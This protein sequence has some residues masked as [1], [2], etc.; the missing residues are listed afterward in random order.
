MNIPGYSSAP[1]H[2]DESIVDRILDSAVADPPDVN[3]PQ[4]A[5]VSPNLPYEVGTVPQLN[6]ADF[7]AALAPYVP[8]W[9]HPYARF[10][11]ANMGWLGEL[12][13]E[14]FRMF[15]TSVSLA[16]V[17][18]LARASRSL[19]AI[20]SSASSPYA[21]LLPLI[22]QAWTD[23]IDIAHVVRMLAA[24]EMM[25]LPLRPDAF[26]AAASTQGVEPKFASPAYAIASAWEEAIMRTRDRV[27]EEI[28]AQAQLQMLIDL[29]VAAWRVLNSYSR[30]T[31]EAL[32]RDSWKR[33]QSIPSA[34]WPPIFDAAAS[35]SRS[36]TWLD[37]KSIVADHTIRFS[38]ISDRVA[39]AFAAHPQ[40]LAEGMLT[41][42]VMGTRFGMT[43]DQY[44]RLVRPIVATR[45]YDLRNGTNWA[46]SDFWNRHPT[47]DPILRDMTERIGLEHAFSSFWSTGIQQKMS[48]AFT[49]KCESGDID[50]VNEVLRWRARCSAFFLTK[51]SAA[52]LSPESG[53]PSEALAQSLMDA[54]S[55]MSKKMKDGESVERCL[56]DIFKQ[57]LRFQPLLLDRWA[58]AIFWGG[59]N[60]AYVPLLGPI[61][62]W[63]ENAV[64]VFVSKNEY[65]NATRACVAALRSYMNIT[66]MNR[67]V[68]MPILTF[69]TQKVFDTMPSEAWGA[70][71][72]YL[73]NLSEQKGQNSWISADTLDTLNGTFLRNPRATLRDEANGFYE[74]L[75]EKAGRIFNQVPDLVAGNTSTF[76]HFCDRLGIP[77]RSRESA[78]RLILLSIV[79]RTPDGTP[80]LHSAV[81]AELKRAGFNDPGSFGYALLAR[82]R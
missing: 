58:E 52:C 37:M 67:R 48:V 15:L 27:Y 56:N 71:L 35:R 79:E 5:G 50:A 29:D 1:Y 72:T 30:E 53:L 26:R 4:N 12:P 49:M 80:H 41:L 43:E 73:D 76:D 51:E 46:F 18:T 13:P 77:I 22:E 82:R 54:I 25:P 75:C 9:A 55:A 6:I 68:V 64:S 7:P 45:L 36:L 23:D 32:K 20:L 44:I 62:Q 10:P 8:T 38:A 47:A 60:S 33:M 78:K 66:N 74:V 42:E 16:D 69:V 21:A 31:G 3:A 61:S 19:S 24:I 34:C 17:A 63:R 14:L 39:V 65:V 11:E 70:L 40:L 81:R 28:D 2:G 59:S 57:P